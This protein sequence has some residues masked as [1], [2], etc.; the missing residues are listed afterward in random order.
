MIKVDVVPTGDTIWG[1]ADR[2]ELYHECTND[3]YR[4]DISSDEIL[5][6]EKDGEIEITRGRKYLY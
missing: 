2:Y 4:E 5:E 3:I 6:L 1:L